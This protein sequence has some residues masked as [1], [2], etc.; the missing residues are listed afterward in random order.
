LVINHS[1]QEETAA[2]RIM[3]KAAHAI[4]RIGHTITKLHGIHNKSLP[5]CLFGGIAPFIEPLLNEDFRQTLVP[6]YAD[7]NVG[8]ILMVR[9]TLA[10][11]I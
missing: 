5:C 3:K 7:A 11:S 2:L 1:Q 10:E 4:D 6:R 9:Q 8:A